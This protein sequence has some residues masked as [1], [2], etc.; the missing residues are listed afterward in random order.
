MRDRLLPALM[1]AIMAA[2]S[3]VLAGERS[4]QG[5]TAGAA[6]LTAAL[7]PGAGHEARIAPLPRPLSAADADLYQHIFR[8]QDD[9]QWAAADREIGRLKDDLLKGHVL[10]RRYLGSGYRPK[11]QELRSW[12]ADYADLPQAEALFKLANTKGI[13][14]FGAIKA[15]VRGY[16][17]GTG[18]DTTDDGATWEDAIFDGDS[19]SSDG[20][21]IKAR[22]R[23]LL[24]QDDAIQAMSLFT[25]A[26]AQGLEDVEIDQL[27][28][29]LAIDHFAG[30]RDEEAAAWAG[31][32]AERSGEQL[33]AAHWIAGLAEWR[34]GKAD[35]A[36]RHFEEAADSSEAPGWMV[37][38]SAFWAARANLVSHRPEVVDHWLEISATYPRTF[39]GLLARRLLGYET[40]F[41]WG[42][43]PFTEADA[44]VLQRVSGGRRALALLQ[45]GEREAAE[46]ELRK[47]YPHAGKT[48]RRSVLALAQTGDM[49]GLAVR[50]GGM[51]PGQTNDTA[52]FPVPAWNPQG[53]WTVDKSLVFAFVRQESSF[54]PRAR[55]DKGAGGLMQIMPATAAA[56]TGGSKSRHKLNDPEYNLG[57]GQR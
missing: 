33:P 7:M 14:G 41:S 9:G 34:M 21:A 46:D 56:I 53:G 8:L 16:L 30:G 54:N 4:H 37:A 55:S 43:V 52:A 57:L 3:P 15:P 24:R 51:A 19:G 27:R 29:A 48:V 28:L 45:L 18:I 6:T 11:Y 31:D 17:K 50:L 22:F 40:L 12:M 20:K 23:Q 44:D 39:Y 42:N 5:T 36:R 2:T 1:I 13:K 38:A 49:P 47:V 26:E 25:R 35:R 10:A 32:A